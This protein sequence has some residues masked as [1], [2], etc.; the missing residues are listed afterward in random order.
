MRFGKEA[1]VFGFCSQDQI[2]QFS[3]SE[4]LDPWRWRKHGRPISWDIVSV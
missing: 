3:S 1:E 4:K 2:V